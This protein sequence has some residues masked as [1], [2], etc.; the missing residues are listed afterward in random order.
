MARWLVSLCASQ[1]GTESRGT[2][3]VYL[4][5]R[6]FAIAIV[7]RQPVKCISGRGNFSYAPGG[8]RVVGLVR[9][10]ARTGR[11]NSEL[12]ERRDNGSNELTQT[13]KP[14]SSLSSRVYLSSR[15][16]SSRLFSSLLFVTPLYPSPLPFAPLNESRT[17]QSCPLFS[18]S[19]STLQSL[20]PLPP[21]LCLLH[22]PHLSAIFVVRSFSFYPALTRAGLGAANYP[23]HQYFLLRIKTE[24]RIITK[25]K[26]LNFVTCS[27]I[28][29]ITINYHVTIN[30]RY[31]IRNSYFLFKT[32]SI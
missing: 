28:K 26:I 22:R 11:E 30:Q 8:E 17:L 3:R 21:T 15:Y 25:I 14:H 18:S 16:L 27:L 2:K 29:E 13:P 19:L 24:N 9:I 7:A 12:R 4:E 5:K 32:F 20:R 23:E 6:R 10:E 31:R 1:W